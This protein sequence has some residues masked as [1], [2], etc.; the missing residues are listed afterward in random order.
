[1]VGE[2]GRHDD[3]GRGKYLRDDYEEE[4]DGMKPGTGNT[5]AS[6]YPYLYPQPTVLPAAC[7]A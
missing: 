2:A 5:I 7:H 1:V 3:E 6:I 4:D